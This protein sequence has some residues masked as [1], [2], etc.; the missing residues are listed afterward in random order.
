MGMWGGGGEM[1]PNLVHTPRDGEGGGG[2]GDAKTRRFKEKHA[3]IFIA[4]VADFA[5]PP[6]PL[7]LPTARKS[8][9]LPAV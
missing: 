2:G 8:K 7:S 5:Q 9:R 1:T 4:L 3:Q 6:P